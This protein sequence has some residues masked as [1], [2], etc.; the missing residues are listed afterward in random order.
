MVVVQAGAFLKSSLRQ[1]EKNIGISNSRIAYAKVVLE[2]AP[3]L[4]SAVLS[5]DRALNDA[6][7]EAQSR[8]AAAQS[9]EGKMDRLRKHAIDLADKLLPW[10]TLLDVVLRE[11]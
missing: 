9:E 3:N 8:K 4:V 7:E 6:D 11:G 1:I 2:Y 10:A 5:G